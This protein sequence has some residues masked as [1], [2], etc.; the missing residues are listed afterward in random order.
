MVGRY[1]DAV[2]TIRYRVCDCAVPESHVETAD[3]EALCHSSV[4]GGEDGS[5]VLFNLHRKWRCCLAFLAVLVF[6]HL[7]TFKY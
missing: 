6:L 1:S 5:L 2:L 3:Q 4:E 7:L